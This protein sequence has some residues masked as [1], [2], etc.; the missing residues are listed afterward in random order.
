MSKASEWF[1][2]K[3]VLERELADHLNARP[4]FDLYESCGGIIHFVCEPLGG[5][6]QIH[7]EHHPNAK[8][9]ERPTRQGLIMLARWILD[10]FADPPDADGGG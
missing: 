1:D 3:L 6:G 10:T 4:T 8:K 7:I 5:D 9:W 2:R